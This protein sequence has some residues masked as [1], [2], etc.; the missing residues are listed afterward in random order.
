MFV[1]RTFK[2]LN[3]AY[4]SDRYQTFFLEKFAY[5]QWNN[6]L[7]FTSGP[8][9]M[10]EPSSDFYDYWKMAQSIES[11]LRYYIKPYNICV[12][13]NELDNMSKSHLLV[14]G[15]LDATKESNNALILMERI[16]Y[17]Q[18]N[19]YMVAI[20]NSEWRPTNWLQIE[21]ATQLQQALTKK[22]TTPNYYSWKTHID[23]IN[24]DSPKQNL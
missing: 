21:D 10:A 4:N 13:G 24:F 1:P 14:R 11:T 22:L 8:A 9:I 23:I 3:I 17:P 12:F 16:N 20:N 6:K 15:W 18:E 7:P 5:Y 19:D 2:R